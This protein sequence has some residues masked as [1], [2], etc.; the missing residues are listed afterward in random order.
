MIRV[1]R[2]H[3]AVE[4]PAPLARR[5]GEQAVHGR[6][7]PDEAQM[8]GE[9]A[10]RGDGRAVD[11]V[12]PLAGL[13]PSAL[14]SKP[15]AELMDC[16]FVLD[17]DRDRESAGAADP[18][19]G[20]ELGAAQAAAG[21]EQRQGLEQIG[22]A[23]AVLAAK[24][25]ERALERKVEAGV[26]AEVAEHQRARTWGRP[27]GFGGVAVGRWPCGAGVCHVRPAAS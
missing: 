1:D 2:Q 15:D 24:D 11:A 9:G 21:R 19:A 7:Q 17:L 3:Q 6:G 20:R 18:R 16:A 12:E 8:V 23:G 4:K 10:R 5:P 13:S 27:S 14:R 22:L 25:D 26:G